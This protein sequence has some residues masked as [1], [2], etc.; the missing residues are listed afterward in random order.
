MNEKIKDKL[1]LLPDAPGV[2]KMYNA[3]NEIIYVG[4]AVSL[5]N[6]VRQY[7]NSAKNQLPKVRAMVAHIEDFEYVLTANEAEALTLECNLIKEFKPRYN[8]LLK[9]D[10]HFPYIRVD[11]K[12]DFPR[13]EVV[14]R[15]KDDGARYLGP[16]LSAIALRDALGVVREHF[17]VRHCKK[18]IRKA[19]VKRERPCLMYHI[20]R[21]CAPCT[22]SVKRE[23]YHRLLDCICSF[24]EGDTGQVLADLTEQMQ[25]ASDNLD[26]KRAAKLR[27]RIYSIKA[28]G[29]KQ[30]V[31]APSY[32]ER[33]VFALA[34]DETSVLV[35]ALFMRGGKVIGT[36]H[37]EMAAEGE[38][39]GDVLESFIKQYY[40]DIGFIPKEILVR[41]EIPE[42]EQIAQWL[43]CK[44]G[45]KVRLV[46]PLRGD[47][48]QLTEMA[49]RNG[50]DYLSKASELKRRE[51]ERTGGA[52]AQIGSI[53]G[54]ENYLGRIECYDNS[55]IHGT[56]TVGCM[57]VFSEGKPDPKNYRRFRIK[58]QT[59][60]DDLAAME[61]MLT[62][63]FEKA[64]E[65]D[66]KFSELPDLL[67]VDG[68][69]GQL[70][71]ALSVLEKFGIPDIP[72]IGLAERNEH[73]ILPNSPEPLVLSRSDPALHLLQRLRDEAHRFAIMYHRSIRAKSALFSRLDGIE[74]IGGSRKRALFDAF[75]TIDKIKAAS[76]EELAAVKGMTRPAAKAVYDHFRMI[77]S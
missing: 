24:L 41:T 8:I 46:V 47:K 48:R 11:L 23:E 68:G 43:S 59:E 6:R 27:D 45:S 9:D 50:M 26:F 13:F 71:I 69:R 39:D 2:Y 5:K 74:G 12:Q 61:E 49:Y 30:Q 35:F 14:R 33:D 58:T 37:Y 63:R 3:L 31:I 28:I 29:E 72:A 66:D 57:V 51:W 76:V 52:L 56:D 34:R 42:A 20:G 60:G 67:V 40:S 53:V 62:R 25:T 22:G 73:I 54:S 4:K 18:D 65:G 36:E 77:D 32:A 38:P 19:I 1:K 55:H 44:R 21:C 15:I 16:Y 17:P 70:N 75:L 64:R 7:F 10:K